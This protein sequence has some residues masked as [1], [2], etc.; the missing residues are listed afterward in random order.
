MLEYIIN[1]QHFDAAS[2]NAVEINSATY[3]SHPPSARAPAY[4]ESYTSLSQYVGYIF[5]NKNV[6]VYIY[7]KIKRE[8]K[9]DLN[10]AAICEAA[11]GDNIYI[12]I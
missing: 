8:K 11:R 3:P 2:P 9:K 7:T 6:L 10:E 5:Q 1:R 4:S 12:Y